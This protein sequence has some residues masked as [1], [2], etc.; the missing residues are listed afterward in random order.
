MPLARVSVRRSRACIRIIYYVCRYISRG[1]R[2]RRRTMIRWPWRDL[3]LSLSFSLFLS[4]SRAERKRDESI[5]I[6]RGSTRKRDAWRQQGRV[7]A[8]GGKDHCQFLR[9]SR[10]WIASNR[11]AANDD[12]LLA[13]EGE[14]AGRCLRTLLFFDDFR[15]RVRYRTYRCYELVERSTVIVIILST[16]LCSM[17]V[18]HVCDSSSCGFPC[19]YIET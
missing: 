11:L 18:W 8:D 9:G 17:L 1:N 4:L 12:Q 7:R 14:R 2:R 15:Y 5:E 3:S 10:F 6:R 16:I 19:C 13:P